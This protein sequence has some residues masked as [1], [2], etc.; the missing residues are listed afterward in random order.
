MTPAGAPLGAPPRPFQD[1][2]LASSAPGRA[3]AGSVRSSAS[4]SRAAHSGLPSGAPEAARDRACEARRAGAA[5]DPRLA[6]QA[7]DG[8]WRADFEAPRPHLRPQ[9]GPAWVAPPRPTDAGLTRYR[10]L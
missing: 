3:F 5:P 9:P 1:A 2:S 8:G 4:S 10:H 7:I 6:P